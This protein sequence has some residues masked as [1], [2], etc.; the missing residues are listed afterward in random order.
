[1]IKIFMKKHF[2]W[3]YLLIISIT[4][5][6]L[7]CTNEEPVMFDPSAEAEEFVIA[8]SYL[9]VQTPVVGFQAG[10]ESYPIKVNVI[11]GVNGVKTLNIYKT[12]N[13][14][15]GNKSNEALLGTYPVGSDLRT[16]IKDDITY[17]ELKQGL[18]I[19]GGALPANELDLAV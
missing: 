10:T 3:R 18:T 9:Q 4:I 13:D 11:N 2:S 1:M 7:S 14:T 5:G 8:D 15:E 6:S 19:D 17:N 12:F 16:V